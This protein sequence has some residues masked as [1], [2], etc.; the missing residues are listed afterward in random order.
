VRQGK[1]P[2]GLSFGYKLF[3]QIRDDGSFSTGER[4]IDPVES[5]VVIQIFEEFAAGKSPRSIAAALN[6]AGVSGPRGA[7]WGASTIYGNWRR[8]TGILNNELYVG[9]LVWNRQRF[10]KDPATGRRQAR[11]NPPDAW[12]TENLD[13]LRI[14][15]QTLLGP[16]QGPP[17]GDSHRHVDG[18]RR[19]TSGAGTA[20]HLS[21]LRA[22]Q[23]RLL[24]R[25]VYAGRQVP[26]RLRQRSQP[27]NLLEL[28]NDP[29]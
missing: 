21:V 23:M 9:K 19:R 13:H 17:G 28:A 29:A 8:G 1:S 4:S 20:P 18:P 6:R 12:I 11:P 25:R 5:A 24:R 22:A 2:G 27:W 26:L 15:D 14:I 16:G 3:R 10:F 7:P